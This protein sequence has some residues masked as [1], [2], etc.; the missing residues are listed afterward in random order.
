MLF[1]IVLV[2]FVWFLV[3]IGCFGIA[4]CI[5]QFGLLVGFACTLLNLLAGCFSSC[6]TVVTTCVLVWGVYVFVLGCLALCLRFCGV[7]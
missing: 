3:W 6:V 7:Y 5:G 4:V 1:T 2:R